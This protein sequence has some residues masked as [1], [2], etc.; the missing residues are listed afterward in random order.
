MIINWFTFIIEMN[1]SSVE[2]MM[3]P[4]I[5]VGNSVVIVCVLLIHTSKQLHVGPD[6]HT[7]FVRWCGTM[8]QPDVNASVADLLRK[9]ISTKHGDN[10]V[11]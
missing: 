4:N 10:G 6:Y 7:H 8:M 3:T 9:R 5:T 11:A 1:C 2:R